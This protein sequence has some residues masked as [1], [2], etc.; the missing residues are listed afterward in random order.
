MFVVVF[1]SRRCG[2]NPKGTTKLSK[3]LHNLKLFPKF[4]VL[5]NSRRRGVNP[6]G[7]TRLS[8]FFL[9]FEIVSGVFCCV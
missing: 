9:Q 2:V 6:K 3:V 5:F 4:F 1:N 8:K 7:T